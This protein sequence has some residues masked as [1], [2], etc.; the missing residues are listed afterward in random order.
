MQELKAK[1]NHFR[2]EG[3]VAVLRVSSRF[4]STIFG[5]MRQRVHSE[6]VPSN[7]EGGDVLCQML[8]TEAKSASQT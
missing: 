6:R 5:I 7:C 8:S 2:T 4:S 1:M 3:L